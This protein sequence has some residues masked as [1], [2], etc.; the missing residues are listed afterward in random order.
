[1]KKYVLESVV[2]VCGATVMIYEL[3]GSRVVAPYLGT[4][5]VVW[6][7]LIGV[8]LGSLSVGYWYGG[9]ISDKEADVKTLSHII[10]L[11]GILIGLTAFLYYDLLFL[12]DDLI[13]NLIAKSIVATLLLF[14]A[15]SFLLGI[16]SPYA[17]KLKAKDLSTMG[18]TVGSLYAVSTTGSIVG[19]FLAGFF[20]IPQFGTN[21]MLTM[22]SSVLIISSI[23]CLPKRY[24]KEKIAALAVS[25]FFIGVGGLLHDAYVV[26]DYIVDI[27]TQYGR[28]QIRDVSLGAIN[29]KLSDSAKIARIMKINGSLSSGILL[30][31]SD[32]YFPYTKYFRLA[33]HFKAD[34]EH[35]LMIGGAG[36]AYPM[37][38]I[39]KHGGATLDVVEI[40]AKLTA[41]AKEHFNLTDDKKLRI[42]HEDGR[43]FI[44]NTAIMYDVIFIDAFSS[45]FSIPHHLTT[46]ESIRRMY[47]LLNEDGVVLVNIISS[48]EGVKSNFLRAEY[49]TFKSIFPHVYL[50]P[51][52]D[53]LDGE[54]IQN[55]M[56]VAL[57][58][59]KK[60]ILT[61]S[62]PTLNAYLGH[63][64]KK[65]ITADVPILSDDYAPV[66]YYISKMLLQWHT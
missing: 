5:L 23:A 53:P 38:Y 4:S 64:W 47:A 65:E 2:F 66:D 56:L 12:I 37:D 41:L 51:V 61:S 24:L 54:K 57:K 29:T 34:I 63:L 16:V 13:R 40:D 9:K 30:D 10:F 11:A 28:V 19:T 58:S 59:K 32:L 48:I 14:A 8:I 50:F 55:I 31:D 7:S 3:V 22:L 49:W 62:D 6:T 45:Y 42:F 33:G 60:P 39:T 15:P 17:V 20:L 46:I 26:K 52:E 27:D 44:N 21:S 18:K 25:V 35:S 36:Y 1:M 43:A